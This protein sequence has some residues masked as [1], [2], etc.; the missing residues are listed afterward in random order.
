MSQ[1]LCS[2]A[3][4]RPRLFSDGPTMWNALT[5]MV[6]YLNSEG[7]CYNNNCHVRPL[8]MPS[9][10]LQLFACNPC[11]AEHVLHAVSMVPTTADAAAWL[12]SCLLHFDGVSLSVLAFFATCNCSVNSG[13]ISMPPRLHYACPLII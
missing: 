8:L 10:H 6:G 13:C 2:A 11:V 12:V 5:T 4:G 1:I 3:A 7:Y 9:P